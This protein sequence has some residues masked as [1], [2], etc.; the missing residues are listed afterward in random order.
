[1][2]LVLI[3]FQRGGTF[4][5]VPA[6]LVM[7]VTLPPCAHSAANTG[8][9][10]ERITVQLNG[11]IAPRSLTSVSWHPHAPAALSLM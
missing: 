6:G 11:G 7:L 5:S 8:E 1:M 9:Q 3:A 2:C 4:F 10:K